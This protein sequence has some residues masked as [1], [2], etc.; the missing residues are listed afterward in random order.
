MMLP[1]FEIG[2]LQLLHNAYQL[3]RG[4]G[5]LPGTFAVVLLPDAKMGIAALADVSTWGTHAELLDYALERGQ[6][7]VLAMEDGAYMVAGCFR[8]PAEVLN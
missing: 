3:G 1:A 7:P 6:V 5:Y 2:M 8:P 4:R